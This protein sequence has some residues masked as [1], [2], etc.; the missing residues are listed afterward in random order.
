MWKWNGKIFP[1]TMRQ[2]S[3]PQET[4]NS[5]GSFFVQFGAAGIWINKSMNM[6]IRSLHCHGMQHLWKND[7]LFVKF[8]TAVTCISLH[9]KWQ[10]HVCCDISHHVSVWVEPG[11]WWSHQREKRANFTV[12]PKINAMTWQGAKRFIRNRSTLS[13]IMNKW[14][15]LLLLCVSSSFVAYDYPSPF[16]FLGQQQSCTFDSFRNKPLHWVIKKRSST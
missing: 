5:V 8:L 2:K 10:A 3:K 9:A 14:C 15:S 7:L 6:L 11:N 4:R 1:T 13:W 12:T 16:V